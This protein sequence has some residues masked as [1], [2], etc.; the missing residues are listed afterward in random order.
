MRRLFLVL[1]PLRNVYGVNGT[2]LTD[3]RTKA[4]FGYPRSD[5]YDQFDAINPKLRT[6][7]IIP[8]TPRRPCKRTW[9]GACSPPQRRDQSMGKALSS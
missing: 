3:R 2:N 8:N 9:D 6:P 1:L 4:V 5:D 7:N